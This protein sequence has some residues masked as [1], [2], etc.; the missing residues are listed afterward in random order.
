MRVVLGTRIAREVVRNALQRVDGLDLVDVESVGDVA[1]LAADAEVLVIS[2]PRGPDGVRI[3]EALRQPG[4]RVKWVQAVTAGVEG[5]LAHGIPDHITVTNQ[6]GAVAPVV[7]EHAMAMI[8]ILARRFVPLIASSAK[9]EWNRDLTPPMFS[10]E[11]K[12]LVVIGFGNIGRNL[13]RRARSF[14][15]KIIGVSRS[16]QADPLAD[17]MVP[18]SALGDALARADAVA[19]CVASNPA[20]HHFMNAA[21]FAKVKPGAVFVNVTRGETVDQE[22]LREALVSGR[23]AS[24]AIDVTTPEPL[25]ADDPLWSAPNL[26][27]T[28]HVAG[29]GGAG[30]G[31][32]IAATVTKNFELYRAGEPL[33]HVVE[34]A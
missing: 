23:L 1:G 8:L 14:D 2:D 7:A 26:F 10:V 19:V 5:L 24:A 20:T 6:G 4:C 12:T 16:G 29:T 15:M 11:R 32:R 25:P 27:I 17:E 34:R 33:R 21:A 22:A 30:T 28:P 9:H 3:A 31:G 13:A 18:F